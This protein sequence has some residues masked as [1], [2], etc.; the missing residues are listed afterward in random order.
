M[1]TGKC[2]GFNNLPM[3]M[4]YSFRSLKLTQ[5]RHTQV[6]VLSE[7]AVDIEVLNLAQPRVL[8]QSRI[9]QTCVASRCTGTH[10]LKLAWFNRSVNKSQSDL[11]L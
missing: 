5:P 11:V 6:F 7:A 4:A 1:I 2:G 8:S 3:G 9:F 10:S